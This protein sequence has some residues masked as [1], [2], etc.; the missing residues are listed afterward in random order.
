MMDV[1]KMLTNDF[2]RLPITKKL[3]PEE[4][5]YLD[6]IMAGL[7]EQLKKAGEWLASEEAAELAGARQQQIDAFFRNSGIRDQI[8]ALIEYNA[9]DSEEFIENFYKE[10]AALGYENIRQLLAYTLAD[11][12]A[13]FHLK[14]YNFDL[15]RSLNEGLRDGIREVIFSGV[16]AGDGYNVT[17]RRLRELPLQPLTYTYYRNGKKIEVTMSPRARAEI[18]ARTEAARAHTTGTL[19]AY[20]N[21]G[22]NDVDII[23]VKDKLVCNMCMDLEANNPHPINSPDLPPIH[24]CCRCSVAAHLET[25]G[26]MPLQDNP[27]VIDLTP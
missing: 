1:E 17:M 2:I 19:Q 25:A 18:I 22:I 20:S 10:G 24:P 21:Y 8:E 12:E 15:I 3:T 13:L 5:T 23:T 26:D 16:A 7:D 9:Q 4:Q 27:Q 6:T 11:Q 14:N